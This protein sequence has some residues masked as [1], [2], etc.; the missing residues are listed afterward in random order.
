MINVKRGTAL[1]SLNL[2]MKPCK[3]RVIP[4]LAKM[5]YVFFFFFFFNL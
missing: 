3:I 4:G 2:G 5:L 1:S